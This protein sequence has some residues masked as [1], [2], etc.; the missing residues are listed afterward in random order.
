[1]DFMHKLAD[2]MAKYFNTDYSKIIDQELASEMPPLY[3]KDPRAVIYDAV[4]P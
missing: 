4:N 1:M 3:E 2:D